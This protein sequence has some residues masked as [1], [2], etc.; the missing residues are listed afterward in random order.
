M[1]RQ[2]DDDTPPFQVGDRVRV[3]RGVASQ[4][5]LG[6]G[7]E[8]RP[9]APKE[10]TAMERRCVVRRTRAGSASQRW[11]RSPAGGASGQAR[12]VVSS[13]S[14]YKELLDGSLSTYWQSSG[15]AA[16]ESSPHWWSSPRRTARARR[17]EHRGTAASSRAAGGSAREDAARRLRLV[18]DGE[19]GHQTR[20][21]RRLGRAAVD[22]RC[23]RRA[24]LPS[25][26]R[27]E[28]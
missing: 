26:N 15:S 1:E 17:A 5:E 8:P 22:G 21:G 13:N 14:D 7:R 11:R 28:P 27:A 25:R 23:R 16:S 2:R 20:Q 19:V 18:V 6:H 12:I 9:S 10:I 3:K 4:H 24:Q